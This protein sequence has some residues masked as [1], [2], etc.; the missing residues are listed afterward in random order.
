MLDKL[1]WDEVPLETV[2]PSMQRRDDW[3]DGTDSCLRS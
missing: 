3:L 2:N 1:S